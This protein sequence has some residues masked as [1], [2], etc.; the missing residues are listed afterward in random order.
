MNSNF[1][2][3]NTILKEIYKGKQL[4]INK[5]DLIGSRKSKKTVNSLL[6]ILKSCLLG[7]KIKV[8]IIRNM[9]DQLSDTWKELKNWLYKDFLSIPWEISE[10]KKTISYKG[11]EIECRSLHKINS[12][13]VKLTGLPS[14]NNYDYVI[15]FIDER[16]EVSNNDNLD[17]TDAIRGAKQL[18]EINSCN[19]WSIFNDYIKSVIDYLPQNENLILK[20]NEQFYINK[21][22]KRIIHF[23]NWKLNEYISDSD[24]D[25]LLELELLDPLSARVRSLGLVGMEAGGIYSHLIPKISRLIQPST[26]FIGGLDY[27]FKKDATATI[28]LGTDRNYQYINV[29]NSLKWTNNKKF[30]DHKQIAEMVIKFYIQEAQKNSYI[31]DYGLTIYCD[32]SNYSFIEILNDTAQKFYC[33]KWLFF[34]ECIKLKLEIRVGKTLALMASE[35]INVSLEAEELIK[36]WR[37]AVWDLKST[38]QIPLDTNNHLSDAFD[39]AIEPWINRISGNI[40]PFY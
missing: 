31:K 2:Y 28:L 18:L 22:D 8:F 39:Y 24:K 11:S 10:T 37:L 38:R 9:S 34:R 25:N 4:S 1:G 5:I 35:R 20:D 23:Q 16:Y 21:L 17:L 12:K 27:G 33:S 26:K 13:D 6:F 3:F 15:R 40:N 7:K 30:L 29:I 32:Y 36:E 14:C 19:P